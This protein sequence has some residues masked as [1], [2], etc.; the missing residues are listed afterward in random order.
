MSRR[1]PREA[2]RPEAEEHQDSPTQPRPRDAQGHELDGWGLPIAGPVRAAR[3][4]ALG[5]PDPN[6]EPEAW[7]ST[8]IGAAEPAPEP[9]TEES[10]G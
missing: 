2:G 3:L 8:S 9:M 10:N 7:A 4:A 6:V 1:P 5:R